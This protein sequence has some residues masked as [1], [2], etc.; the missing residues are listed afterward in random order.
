MDF[1]WEAARE[2]LG[3]LW[4]RDPEML[5][6]IGVSLGVSTL[7]V[8]VAAIL[9]VPLGFL[10][11]MARFR[12]RRA[13]VGL[14]N[15]AMAVPTVVVGLFVFCLICRRGP[16]GGMDLLFTPWAM[17]AGQT[18][19]A[20]P[21]LAALTLAAVEGADPRISETA[22]TLGAGGARTAWAVLAEC[23]AAMAAA[24]VAGF[25]RVFAEVGVSM[26]L[27]GNIRWFT[28]NVTTTIALETAKGE[29]GMGLALGA[30]LLVVAL[31]VNLAVQ[32]L[33]APP[34]ER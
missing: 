32:A 27:G 1:L 24:V 26:M 15:T 28:R 22:R 7:A 4:R 30:V 13:A 21:I 20:A 31:A 9:G 5:H 25:G 19:L 2:A 12:G 10:L 16:F 14:V 23:R 6:A 34:A 33:R 3:L 8:A 29:F 11:G 18:I 17:A